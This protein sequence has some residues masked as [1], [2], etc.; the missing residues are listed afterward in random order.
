VEADRRGG[1][2][3]EAQGRLAARWPELPNFMSM[4]NIIPLHSERACSLRYT[5]RNGTEYSTMLA[6]SLK[7]Y[8]VSSAKANSS[9][10]V[11][12]HGL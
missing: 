11:I 10:H 3:V 4:T 5:Q 6:L 12:P 9:E 2:K 8:D 1:G 7:M